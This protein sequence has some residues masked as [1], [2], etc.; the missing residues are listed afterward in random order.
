MKDIPLELTEDQEKTL[1]DDVFNEV[2]EALAVHDLREQRNAK[3]L[4]AYKA[5]PEL[6]KK[7][8]PWP[9]AANVVVPVVAIAV[10]AMV[11]RFQRAV[12]G[13]ADLCE[14]VIQDPTQEFNEK[15]FRDWINY[16]RDAGRGKKALRTIIHDMALY[17]DGFVK[18]LWVEEKV[19][20][21]A[22]DTSGD[23]AV[24]EVTKYKGPRWTAPS[25]NDILWPFGFD[26]WDEI[27]WY[28]HRLRMTE[29]ELRDRE[30][31]ELDAV[32]AVLGRGPKEREGEIHN[33]IKEKAQ[34]VGVARF[35]DIIEITWV[36]KIPP[37]QEGEEAV[38][39]PVILHYSHDTR[40]FL[41][42]V[43][44]PFF[45]HARMM[46]KFP[47]LY[48]PHEVEGAGVAE[49][50]FPFQQEASTAHNQRIDSATSAIAGVVVISPD[51]NIE[52]GKEVAPGSLIRTEN[53]DRDVRVVHL[54]SGVAAQQM[55]NIEERAM[56]LSGKATKVSDY[57]LGMESATVGSRAT[58]TG[59]TALLSQSDVLQWASL[60]DL[61]ESITE[62]IYLTIQLVQ[63]F[64]P[65]GYE[66]QPGKKI[67]FPQGDVRTTLGLKIKV[68]D[69]TFNK[70]LEIQQL[71]I[72]MQVLQDYY[73]KLSSGV[74]LL[75]NPQIPPAAKGTAIQILLSSQDLVRRFVER[76]EIA[77][78]DKIVPNILTIIE[79]LQGAA[80]EP[81]SPQPTSQP[82]AGGPPQGAGGGAPEMP[83]PPPAV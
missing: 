47:F 57:N 33:Y 60:D 83:P 68:S 65:E 27:P 6:E 78:I 18:P 59:T 20:Q 29:R 82:P 24:S 21:H 70:D 16:I 72:V 31:F 42:K 45:N 50:A 14:V 11:A 22:Y 13:L 4:K 32:D 28:G 44:N 23:V 54:S 71:Q 63:Q 74:M 43:Y 12:L 62:L 8:Y 75:F 46:V 53:P 35:Y 36:F 61:R 15:V 38:F 49:K 76:F 56:H 37:A 55:E 48:Q 5:K 39:N 7:S 25:P 69:E 30:D 51:A 3:W 40:R 64:L 10:D 26:E 9:G 80:A 34:A 58:A 2:Q 79:G 81:G 67:V 52:G 19:V 41:K 66:F 1:L 17:G 73:T 77:D